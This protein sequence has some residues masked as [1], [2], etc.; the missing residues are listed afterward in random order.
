MAVDPEAMDHNTAV[1]PKMLVV[2]G[3]TGL[4]EETFPEIQQK[5]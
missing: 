2:K 3:G 4:W 1:L 5:H